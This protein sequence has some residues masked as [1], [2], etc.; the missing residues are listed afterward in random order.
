MQHRVLEEQE[1]QDS[2][3]ISAFRWEA[4][5]SFIINTAMA[6]RYQVFV[7]FHAMRVLRKVIFID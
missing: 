3:Q 6:Q 2:G 4:G 7:Y 5:A 1:I